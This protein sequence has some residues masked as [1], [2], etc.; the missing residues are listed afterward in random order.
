[1]P[2]H[3]WLFYPLARIGSYMWS[4]FWADARVQDTLIGQ[5][6]VE[7]SEA[8]GKTRLVYINDEYDR[9][10]VRFISANSWVLGKDHEVRRRPL[11]QLTFPQFSWMRNESDAS[12]HSAWRN[13]RTLM[14]HCCGCEW[15]CICES[16]VR[17]A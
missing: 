13:P 7:H 12:Y 6:V 3:H 16:G 11:S 15:T 10:S 5:T 1:M 4:M 2:P 8:R 14:W 9:P 17:L